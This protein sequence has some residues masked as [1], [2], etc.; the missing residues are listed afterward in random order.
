[1]SIT[2]WQ[3]VMA[4]AGT[5]RAVVDT[6]NAALNKVLQSPDVIERLKQNGVAPQGGSP[7]QAAS[8]IKQESDLWRSIA[9][10]V[11]L[12]PGPL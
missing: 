6:L 9:R 2:S 3:A 12:V 1:M 8:F 4:P 7:A 5:P 11:N 10:Q